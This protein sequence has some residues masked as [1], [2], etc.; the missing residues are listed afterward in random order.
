MFQVRPPALARSREH[1]GPPRA[2]PR[3]P[4]F[5]LTAGLGAFDF[6]APGGFA[7]GRHRGRLECGLDDHEIGDLP[8]KGRLLASI[9]GSPF[10]VSG[11][12]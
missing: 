4:R 12:R 6:A 1:Q 3:P 7:R 9:G 10:D 8:R 11:R 2:R 5:A